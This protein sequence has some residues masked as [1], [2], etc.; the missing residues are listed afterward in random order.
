MSDTANAKRLRKRYQREDV[1]ESEHGRR[2]TPEQRYV[3]A[4]YD[5]K[6]RS[7]GA[8]EFS[9]TYE[10]YLDIICRR[11]TY[12]NGDISQEAGSGLDR[13]DNEQGYIPGNVNP[14]CASCNRRRAKT[15]S[16]E[17]FKK[18]SLINGYWKNE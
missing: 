14:C 16:A 3:K 1:K 5:A 2:R 4:K 11:C 17:E 18:Q 6:R 15:M 10:S 13:I 8:K 7:S 12:C 9:L